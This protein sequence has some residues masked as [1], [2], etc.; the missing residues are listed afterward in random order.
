M[1]ILQVIPYFSPAYS[2]GG[3]VR[4][5]Y[6]VSKELAKRGHEVTIYTTDAS[7]LTARLNT[8]SPKQIDGMEVYYFR[9][10]SMKHIKWLKLFVTPEL[11]SRARN[12]IQ[13]F[14]AIHLREYTTFQNIVIHHYAV[15]RK[16]SYVLQA[17]GSLPS[18][19]GEKQGLKRIYDMLFGYRILKDAAK[20][21]V[22]NKAEADQHRERGV[23]E[24]K[25]AVIP[26]GIDLSEYS[27]LPPKERIKERFRIPRNKKIILCLGRLHKI[28]GIDFLLKAQA[29]LSKEIGSDAILVIAGSD[30]GYLPEIRSLISNLGLDNEV[31]LTG[32]LYG[33]NKLEAYAGSEVVVL[34]S[35]YEA[36]PNTI[37]EAYACSRP[38]IASNVGSLS[39]LVLNGKTGYLFEKGSVDELSHHLEFALSNPLDVEKMG[40][41]GRKFVE[42]RFSIAKVVTMLE[43][44]YSTMIN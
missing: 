41:E 29:K 22:L 38:V 17:H 27:S 9:N 20:T 3:P 2:F 5:T 16:V 4:G 10:V 19:I 25:M 1:K 15:K 40:V 24:E 21:V 36:F 14:D 7:D 6:L 43:E 31:L 33:M 44:L 32:P 11:I 18:N 28:K 39:D 23:P 35:R 8:E 42:T 34:P 13:K 12:E 37:L 26:N 30:D